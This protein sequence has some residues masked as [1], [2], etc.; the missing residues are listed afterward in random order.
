MDNKIDSSRAKSV[1]RGLTKLT[2]A[3]ALGMF[4][5][6]TAPEAFKAFNPDIVWDLYALRN[7]EQYLSY[8]KEVFEMCTFPLIGMLIGAKTIKYVKGAYDSFFNKSIEAFDDG[9]SNI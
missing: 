5:Y 1:I 9:N 8:A 4:A 6:E 3:T 7:D 2:V